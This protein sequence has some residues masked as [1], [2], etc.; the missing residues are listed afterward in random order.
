M[1]DGQQEINTTVRESSGEDAFHSLAKHVG[2]TQ[3]NHKVLRA[4]R[5]DMAESSTFEVDGKG[6]RM[7]GRACGGTLKIECSAT[8]FTLELPLTTGFVNDSCLLAAITF[9]KDFSSLHEKES[10]D[11]PEW[12]TV[13]LSLIQSKG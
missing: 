2:P 11:F 1:F 12:T 5:Q 10:K 6:C 13:A 4:A 9:F 3:V 7:S 8:I